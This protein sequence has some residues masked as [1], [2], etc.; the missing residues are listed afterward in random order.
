MKRAGWRAGKG[1]ADAPAFRLPQFLLLRVHAQEISFEVRLRPHPSESHQY[2]AAR[3]LALT[4]LRLAGEHTAVL[5]AG[6]CHGR[7]PAVFTRRPEGGYGLWIAVGKLP[8]PTAL[9]R[10]ASLAE[11]VVCYCYGER[12]RCVAALR[13]QR[14]LPRVRVIWLASGFLARLTA[15]L[16]PRAHGKTAEWEVV[17]ER[18]GEKEWLRIAGAVW[19]PLFL[20][21]EGDGWRAAAGR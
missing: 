20:A 15:A 7:E 16:E 9:R 4:V 21:G 8:D 3:L 14:L 19:R 5:S 6:L 2:L 17:V 12:R 1:G 10:A 11:R 18:K 13:G